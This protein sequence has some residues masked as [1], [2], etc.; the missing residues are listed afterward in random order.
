MLL[1]LVVGLCSQCTTPRQEATDTAQDTLP[2]TPP[3]FTSLHATQTHVNFVNQLEE[4]PNT[5]ILMYEYFYNGGGVAA[6]D[7]NGDGRVDLYFTANMGSNVLYLNQGDFSFE[8]VTARAGVAGR[9]GPWKTGVTFV[10][11]NGDRRLDIYVCYSG[12]L[13]EEK[14][15][16]QLFINEGNDEQGVPRFSERAAAYG[17]ASTAFSNQIYFF[18]YDRDGDLDAALLNHNPK[19]LPVLN[20]VTTAALLKQDDPQRGL[21]LFNQTNQVFRDVTR[22]AGIN[23]SELS[24]GLGLGLGDFNNDGWPDFYVSNDYTIP[25]YLYINNRNGT[26]TNTVQQ[27][28][29][30][31]SHFSM[32]NDVADVNN[33]GWTDVMTLDMQPEDNRRQKLLLA[34]DNWGKFD[35]MLKSGFHYQYMRNMLQLNNGNGTFSEVGQWAGVAATDWSW[36]P[37]FADYDQDGWK[38]LYITNGYHRDYTNLDFIK[39]MDDVVRTRGRLK[40]EDV[41]EIIHHMPASNVVNYMFAGGPNTQFKNQTQSWGFDQAAN[42]Q[43]AAYADL[44]NDGDLDMVVNNMN[45]PAFIYRNESAAD[46]H[47]HFLKINLQGAGL[48]TFGIGTR[49]TA[50]RQGQV[51]EAWQ[52]PT[53]GYLSSV[54]PVVHMGLGSWSS[55]DSLHIQWP[56]GKQQWLTDIKAD[57]VLTIQETAAQHTKETKHAQP[58]T[59]YHRA[60]TPLKHEDVSPPINDYKRQALLLMTQSHRG[61]C[62][63]AGDVNGDGREDIM[64]GGAAGTPAKLYLQ[65]RNGEFI[66]HPQPAFVEDQASEDQDVVLVDVNA[67]GLL[68]VYI[69]SGG[70]HQWTDGDA[71]LQDRLYMGDGRGNFRK[72]SGRLPAMRTSKRCVAVGDVNRDGFADLFVGGSTV[73][74]RFPES[75]PNYLLLNDGQGHFINEI[76]TRAPVLESLSLVTD[77][78]WAD[79]DLDGISELIVVGDFMPVSIFKWE[80]KTLVDA[81]AS[82]L[83]KTYAGC[84]NTLHVADINRD[85]K[86]DLLVGNM[87]LNTVCRVSDSEPG[88][89]YFA[90][91]DNNGS[92][93]PFFSFYIQGKRYPYLTR[94]ELLEQVGA[95]R[96]RFTDYASYADARLEDLY[97]PERWQ[98]AGY[99]KI[100]YLATAVFCSSDTGYHAVSLPPEAQYA[101]VYAIAVWDANGDGAQDVLLAGNTH[102]ARIRMGNADANQGVLLQGDGQ[103]NFRY[104]PQRVS[105]FSMHGDVRCLLARQ[106][107]VLAG[108]QNGPLVA[109]RKSGK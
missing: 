30:H 67:D 82:Y 104:V 50:H 36:A 4:G 102:H 7:V 49:I 79:L 64:L 70:Y 31:T 66:N 73:P 78:Q 99:K 100:N 39:Y 52:N 63:A 75:S 54:D 94:D 19:S 59:W 6:G 21:R 72:E 69:V 101:P 107:L 51:V 61:P 85:G 83:D 44:D 60:S 33:D 89:L 81:T 34:P 11:V 9:E 13:P 108:I 95:F 105:G 57:Q 27:S 14:R 97:P 20:E 90:D 87:G 62:M 86:P 48:N 2:K 45:K 35:L 65:Q 41:L 56:T 26:F 68:D 47:H 3:L 92:V 109:Y 23:G 53:R 58:E 16:N 84:W 38:D 77:A 28:M 80:Q 93:D 42:S 98:S 74:G 37:L 17:L 15:T 76:H 24:Y 5:N 43:G 55:V 106:G 40:R 32:G 46:A 12:M 1:I 96:R 22:D 18:D 71:V 8:D 25:D 88:E 103:G 29:E 10:D 91:F